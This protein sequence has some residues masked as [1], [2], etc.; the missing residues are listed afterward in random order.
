MLNH[1]EG[2]WV[3]LKTFSWLA[4]FASITYLY[5]NWRTDQIVR[6]FDVYFDIEL[7]LPF[8]PAATYFYFSLPL[9]FFLPPLF[10]S[11]ERLKVLQRQM[12]I[13]CLVSLAF[14]YI[15]PAPL[16]FIR[17]VPES[18]WLSLLY[19]IDRPNNASF[20]LFQLSLAL[21]CLNLFPVLSFSKRVLLISG[22]FL[23]GIAGLF[24]WQ[25]HLMGIMTAW[26]CAVVLRLSIR[27]IA[28]PV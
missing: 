23:I 6:A 5:T 3:Y 18:S 22:T 8:I 28:D 21:I 16:A 4:P 13:G 11:V 17:P 19:Q 25:Q 1:K 7:K 24:I 14:F 9:L 20:S 15:F 10:L 2:W 26:V 12:F 27:E